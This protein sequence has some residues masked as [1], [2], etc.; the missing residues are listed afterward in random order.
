MAGTTVSKKPAAKATASEPELYPVK[1]IDLDKIEAN[2]AQSRGMGA[3]SSLQQMG[4]GLFEKIEQD[5]EPIWP[6][7]ISTDADKRRQ[8]VEL[9]TENETSV[10][11]TAE[12][13]KEH[14]QLQPIGVVQQKDGS[15]DVV[16]GMQRAVAAAFNWARE[17]DK[18]PKKVEAKIMP[19]SAN[20]DEL[21]LKLRSRAENRVRKA[22]SPIDKAYFYKELKR[23]FKLTEA[24]IAEREDCGPQ[25][26]KDILSMLDPKL[27]DKRVAI[28]TGEM[29]VD[30]ALKLLRRRRE[31]GETTEKSGDGR[32]RARFPS[33]K[34]ISNAYATGV[35]PKKMDDELWEFYKDE[36]VRRFIAKSLGFKFKPYVEPA[37]K[38]AKANKAAESS[39]TNG[40]AKKRTFKIARSLAN[41]LL[42]CLGQTNAATWTDAQAK[43]KLESITNLAEEG[44]KVE[45]KV[46]QELLD[47]LLGAYA[48]GYSIEFSAAK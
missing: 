3:L 6:M 13:L 27:E 48:N 7:L 38:A 41:K 18:Y 19:E 44:Q 30:P 20:K 26:I 4:H 14:G 22:E 21:A 35:K 5:K 17:P 32:Q 45:G 10:F 9:I 47:K 23:E 12:S 31:G 15:Y 24:Q 46:T 25:H 2:T 1:L 36:K 28:H 16:Y 29:G 33:V 11:G 40:A 34:V 8:V 39:G 37:A 42:I 43:A